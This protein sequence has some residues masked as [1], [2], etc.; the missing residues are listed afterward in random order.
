LN[1]AATAPK[2]AVTRLH[3]RHY[4]EGADEYGKA[5]LQGH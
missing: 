3:P 1:S 4:T 2:D 5:T